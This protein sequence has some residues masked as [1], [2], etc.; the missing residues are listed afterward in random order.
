[1]TKDDFCKAIVNS[2]NSYDINEI[3]NDIQTSKLSELD[4]MELYGM[5]HI[6]KRAV[7]FIETIESYTTTLVKDSY[8]KKKF[9]EAIYNFKENTP[10][11]R[12][13]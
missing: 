7:E 12:E 2:K 1:M 3:F 10:M 13:A 4:K 5:I 8:I 11:D 6:M 9:E